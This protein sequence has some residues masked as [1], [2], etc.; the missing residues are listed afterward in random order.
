MMRGTKKPP[1]KKRS[2]SASVRHI[3]FLV[4][5]L[6]LQQQ[7]EEL[8]ALVHRCNRVYNDVELYR[9]EAKWPRA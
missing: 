4:R 6:S 2:T 7:Q 5:K 1:T 8:D 9:L 3:Y